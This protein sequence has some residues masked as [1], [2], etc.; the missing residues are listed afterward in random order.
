MANRKWA[1]PNE[2]CDST[3][4]IKWEGSISWPLKLDVLQMGRTTV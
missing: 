4:Q 1:N 2:L 3:V